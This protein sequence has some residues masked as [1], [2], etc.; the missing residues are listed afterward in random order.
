MSRSVFDL[1]GPAWQRTQQTLFRP[2]DAGKWFVI[3]FSC[4]LA[5][6][7][8]GGA[9]TWGFDFDEDSPSFTAFGLPEFSRDGLGLGWIVGLIL[10]FLALLVLFIWVSSRGKLVFLHNVA[11]NRAAISEPWRRFAPEANSLFLWRLGFVA[12]CLLVIAGVAAIGTG[13][14]AMTWWLEPPS[15]A[16]LLPAV[17][18]V[19]VALVVALF[20]IAVALFLDSFVVPIM[21]MERST[22]SEAWSRFWDLLHREPGAFVI[23]AVV[24][25]LS[26]VALFAAVLLAGFA[27]CCLGFLFLSIPYLSTVFLLPFHVFLRAFSLELLAKVE[28]RLNAFEP[29]NWSASPDGH[30]AL[31]RMTV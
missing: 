1:V 9:P 16:A 12:V 27:T 4:W 21:A 6:L 2:F 3:G 13:L 7:T 23:Y 31:E 24:V 10:F 25:V 15:G 19:L 18:L 11:K 8:Q 26:S 30:E 20:A 28:P 14:G 29:A 17:S 5:G 22:T